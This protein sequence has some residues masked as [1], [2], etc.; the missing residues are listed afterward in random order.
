[1]SALIDTVRTSLLDLVGGAV[2]FLPGLIMAIAVLIFT[3]S[4]V[5]PVQKLTKVLTERLTDN[6]SL[7]LLA[8]KVAS[9]AV[10][11]FGVLF[12]C[13]LTFPGLGLGDIIA[14]LGLSSVAIGFAFQDIFKNFL[15][16]ILLLLNQPFRVSDQIIVGNYEGTVETI[17]IRSTKIRNYQGESVLIP[18]SVVF[19][20]PIEVL[21]ENA[22]RRSDLSIGLDYNTPLPQ[23]RQLLQETTQGVNGV[24]ADPAV[25][26][27][28]V[29]FGDSSIDFAVRYWTRPPKAIVRRTQTQVILALKAACDRADLN[30]PYPIRTLYFFNQEQFTDHTA[31]PQK[32]GPAPGRWPLNGSQ[33]KQ[34][35]EA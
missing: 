14:L 34:P 2:E 8:V 15:A 26:V 19:T 10:W 13:I 9:V 21:T 28:I 30:I 5:G 32:Q 22:C 35:V 27:D 25:E 11:V 23:A 24:L 31:L 1:M 4:G 6:L 20:S 17:D 7:R 3:R 12:A 33:A 29:G 16:G 18:N